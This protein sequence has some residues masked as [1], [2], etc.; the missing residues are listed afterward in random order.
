MV[1]RY[2]QLL[3]IMRM[4]DISWG[5]QK[6]ESVLPTFSNSI[7]LRWQTSV[8]LSCLGHGNGIT[9]ACVNKKS[10]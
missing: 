3:Q 10:P 1:V 7:V 2:D 5:S 6:H 8:T 9:R 4:N